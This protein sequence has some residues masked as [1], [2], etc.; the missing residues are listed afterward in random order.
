MDTR[1]ALRLQ[2]VLIERFRSDDWDECDRVV[3][4]NVL[5]VVARALLG[6]EDAQRDVRELIAF[7]EAN[8]EVD[9][10]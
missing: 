6:D 1:A 8:G 9:A 4:S 7:I 2:E 3:W 5:L 10:V